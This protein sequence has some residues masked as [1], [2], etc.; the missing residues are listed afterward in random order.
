MKKGMFSREAV[1][2]ASM[3][4]RGSQTRAPGC[5]AFGPPVNENGRGSGSLGERALPQQVAGTLRSAWDRLGP[6]GTG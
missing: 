4:R 3:R 2:D 5:M 6:L 1:K